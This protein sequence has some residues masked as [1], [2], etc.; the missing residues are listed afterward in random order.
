MNIFFS[1]IR[2]LIG[3]AAT[4]TTIVATIL[5]YIFA[6]KILPIIG[7]EPTQTA[8]LILAG[9]VLVLFF[10]LDVAFS[11]VGARKNN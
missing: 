8:S 6:H 3:T 9:I 4:L 1:T 10:I 7:I 11:I 2:I 5:S